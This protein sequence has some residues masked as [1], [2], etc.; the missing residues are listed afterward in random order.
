MGNLLD[1]HKTGVNLGDSRGWAPLRFAIRWGYK[2][3][4]RLLLGDERVE[5]NVHG[6]GNEMLLY[7][8]VNVENEAVVVGF[9]LE[10]DWIEVDPWSKDDRTPLNLSAC[11]GYTGAVRALLKDHRAELTPVMGTVGRR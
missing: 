4:T 10:D 2:G 1:D 6:L 7:I 9:L 11:Y 8:T 5:V 3:I